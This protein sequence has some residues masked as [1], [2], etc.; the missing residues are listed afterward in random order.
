V[1]E[2]C[3]NACVAAWFVLFWHPVSRIKVNRFVAA[4][5]GMAGILA[6]VLLLCEFLA[7]SDQVHGAFHH[8]GN[9]TSNSCALCL[10]VKG[11]VDVPQ[12]APFA[13]QPIL[14]S[15]DL[16]SHFESIALVDFTYL[17]SPSRAPPASA[18]KSPVV[19]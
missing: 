6:A 12:P 11:L 17:V 16:V 13:T 19:A 14:S 2:N 5:R 9:T 7:T 18:S 8:N 4:C 15:F 1:R 3:N 10:F